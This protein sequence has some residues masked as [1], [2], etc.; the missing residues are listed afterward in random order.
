[1]D[2][3][4][5][6]LCEG[7]PMGVFVVDDEGGLAYGN[8]S[9]RRMVGERSLVEWLAALPPDSS[10]EA[11]ACWQACRRDGTPF[12]LMISLP[13]P[14]PVWL[15]WRG[16]RLADGRIGGTL[17][18]VTALQRSGEE[19]EAASRAKS[20]FLA[21][22]SHEIR[23][24]MNAIIGMSDLLWETALDSMQ[25]RYVGI[26]RDA[27]EHLLGLLNDIL[28]LSK[29][30]AGELRLERHD[31]SVR[32][33]I[34]KATELIAGRART[35]G[36]E[37]AADIAADVP[38]RVVG[39]SLRLRQVLMNLLSNAVKFTDKGEIALRVARGAGPDVLRFTV[40]DSGIGIAGEK[41]KRLFH[42]FM[43]LADPSGQR[44][45]GTG[46]GLSI[47]RRLVEMMGGRIW[48]ESVEGSGST[49][50]F[51]LPL[52]APEAGQ[53]RPSG[54]SVNLRGM[55]ALVADA[56][57]TGR[58]ILREMLGGWGAA[59]EEM[60]DPD[61]LRSRLPAPFDILVLARNL[62]EGGAEL[63]RHVRERFEPSQ[64][65]IILVVSDVARDDDAARKELGISALVMKPVKRRDL[66]EA[67]SSALSGEYRADRV[68]GAAPEPAPPRRL[69][70]L[71]ADDSEDNRLLVRA[72]L[73]DS[74]H[75]LDVAVDG[76]QAVE[77]AGNINYDLIL[78]DLEMPVMSG[79]TA[80]REIRRRE[81]EHSLLPT[82]ILALTAHTLPEQIERSLEAGVNGHL[83]K[84]LRKAE[85]V[86]AVNGA[87]AAPAASGPRLHVAVTP[88]VAPLVPTFLANRRKDVANAR[89]ALERRDYHSLWVLA[90]TMK[91]LGASYGFDGISDIGV[92]MERA[93][94]SREQAALSRAVDALE[95]YLGQVDFSVAS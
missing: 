83:H 81:R 63:V 4:L 45:P 54:I 1:M 68:R 71:L 59:V 48:F 15:R 37:F 82:P 22:M 41:Q 33:Q 55:R 35:K 92:E 9:W 94:L 30:E 72:F 13:G 74:G 34:E 70:I 91:G 31:L 76:Q 42:P 65:I 20:E 73:A 11:T 12:A 78:M 53:T 32:E 86:A 24:P 2:A 61:A 50:V 21:N 43:Q 58:L 19:A 36:I 26:L 95:R 38:P 23:T 49:F 16:L 56:N 88:T 7:L 5:S 57:P 87:V 84:P 25:R 28:D 47:S 80:T 14:A 67:L 75:N 85:L 93:A 89:A 69:R 29:I 52:P 44:A 17:D 27:G 62:N 79:F 8:A 51:E 60:S 3:R 39:D 90:H 64:L 77:L 66:M 10:A 46:L 6:E 40:H 18:D